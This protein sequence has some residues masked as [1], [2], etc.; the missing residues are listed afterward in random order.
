MVDN[1]PDT[2]LGAGHAPALR[3]PTVCLPRFGVVLAARLMAGCALTTNVR[4]PSP[5][6]RQIGVIVLGVLLVLEA[7]FGIL[8]TILEEQWLLFIYMVSTNACARSRLRA[9]R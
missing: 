9:C 6:P 8:A 2:P 7:V 1:I 5:A 4:L 3:A